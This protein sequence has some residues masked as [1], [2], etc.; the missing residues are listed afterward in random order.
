M[1]TIATVHVNFRPLSGNWDGE[2]WDAQLARCSN[3]FLSGPTPA[4]PPAGASSIEWQIVGASN[5]DD[6]VFNVSVDLPGDDEVIFTGVRNNTVTTYL[7][8]PATDAVGQDGT[9]FHNGHRVDQYYSRG[10]YI[11]SVSG[12]SAPF[13]VNVVPAM[14]ARLAAIGNVVGVRTATQLR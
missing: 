14:P 2:H 7:P 13:T 9:P 10:I 1:T 8:T 11:A 6:I 3:N 5:P 4:V 12:A